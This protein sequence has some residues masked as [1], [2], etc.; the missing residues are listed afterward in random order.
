MRKR[1]LALLAVVFTAGWVGCGVWLAQAIVRADME[2]LDEW[3]KRNP[4]YF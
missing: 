2:T 4:N 3:R 1:D